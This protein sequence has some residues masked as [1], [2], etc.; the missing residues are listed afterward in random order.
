MMCCTLMMRGVDSVTRRKERKREKGRWRES[1]R[2]VSEERESKRERLTWVSW[3]H[4][5]K[6]L[7]LRRARRSL[8][9]RETSSLNLTFSSGP[10]TILDIFPIVTY[11]PLAVHSQ[12]NRLET[13]RYRFVRAPC[14]P[15]PGAGQYLRD[16]RASL[17]SHSPNAIGGGRS[18]PN[19]T[20][21]Q[22]SRTASSSAAATHSP[23]RP[24]RRSSELRV[25]TPSHLISSHLTPP[26]PHATD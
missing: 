9:T 20:T 26:R 10:A 19:P 5:N 25:G 12:T 17:F 3:R 24:S 7:L 15:S 16:A 1:E 6:V 22:P 4:Q 8:L 13:C 21:S 11:Y 23:S 2:D 18:R 14:S